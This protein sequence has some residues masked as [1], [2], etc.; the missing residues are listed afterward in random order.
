MLQKS[1]REPGGNRPQTL[2]RASRADAEGAAERGD[3]CSHCSRHPPSTSHT[4][5]L[6]CQRLRSPLCFPEVL[7]VADTERG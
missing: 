6:T 3:P 2:C 5:N 4:E 7:P 1:L